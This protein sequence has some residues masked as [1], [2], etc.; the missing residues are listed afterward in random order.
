MSNKFWFSWFSVY[1]C[2]VAAV[3]VDHLGGGSIVK[4]ATAGFLLQTL[5]IYVIWKVVQEDNPPFM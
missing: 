3:G 5:F 4:A 2:F 1:A